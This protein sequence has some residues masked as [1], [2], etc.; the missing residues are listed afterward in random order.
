MAFEVC[1]EVKK[2]EGR[3]WTKCSIR[4]FA[5]AF[6]LFL[7]PIRLVESLFSEFDTSKSVGFCRGSRTEGRILR[8]ESPGI[9][10]KSF[11]LNT[12]R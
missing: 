4:H 12:Q 1:F 6:H 3:S 8:V 10:K 7:A 11:I 2:Y 5:M 9:I